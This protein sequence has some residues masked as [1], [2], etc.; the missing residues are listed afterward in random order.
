MVQQ[1]GRICPK[2]VSTLVLWLSQTLW[3]V[4]SDSVLWAA[5]APALA[6]MAYEHHGAP[7]C[8]Q[9]TQAGEAGTSARKPCACDSE[10]LWRGCESWEGGSEVLMPMPNTCTSLGA[11]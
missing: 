10:A 3:L 11:V 4:H 9:H 2:T 5:R 7:V 1:A 6:T 8:Q